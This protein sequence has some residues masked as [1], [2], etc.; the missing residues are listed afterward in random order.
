M[1]GR[2]EAVESPILQL[3]EFRIDFWVAQ[4]FSAAAVT[5]FSIRLQPLVVSFL[6]IRLE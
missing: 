5:C 4:R 1:T 6:Q 2:A 3:I